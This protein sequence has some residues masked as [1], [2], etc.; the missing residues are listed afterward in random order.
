[1]ASRPTYGITTNRSPRP[2]NSSLD[3]PRRNAPNTAL[4]SDRIQGHNGRCRA[5]IPQK[6]SYA[7]KKYNLSKMPN[8]NK[9]LYQICNKLRIVSGYTLPY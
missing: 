4:I 1:M 3:P 8:A 6:G 5:T 9:R 2:V 7:A